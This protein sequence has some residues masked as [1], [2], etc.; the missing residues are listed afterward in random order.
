MSDPD[1]TKAPLKGILKKPVSLLETGPRTVHIK[2]KD[3]FSFNSSISP[4]AP[5]SSAAA[6]ALSAAPPPSLALSA[7]ELKVERT[8]QLALSCSRLQSSLAE[9]DDQ[10]AILARQAQAIQS[11][12]V[13]MGALYVVLGVG[14]GGKR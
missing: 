7:A 1:N 13:G 6:S 11:L 3:S 8:R 4:A 2:A 12:G 10:M 5:A 14:V 9:L